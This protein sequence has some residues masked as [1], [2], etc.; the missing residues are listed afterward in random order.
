VVCS[1][2]RLRAVPRWGR[3][4]SGY[5]PVPPLLAEAVTEQ[6]WATA[7]LGPLLLAVEDANDALC[8][9]VL[10]LRILGLRDLSD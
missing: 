4:R 2:A 7:V 8:V 9:S 10:A 1:P 3:R 5:E 6:G